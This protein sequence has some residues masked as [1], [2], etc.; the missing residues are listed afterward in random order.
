MIETRNLTKR[1]GD[2]T[3]LSEANFTLERGKIT[4]FIGPNGAGKTTTMKL[5]AQTLTPSSGEMIID[6]REIT[7]TSDHKERLL[8]RRQIGYLAE[9]NPL[10]FDMQC[11][12]FLV[13]NARIR[14]FTGM[15]SRKRVAAVAEQCHLGEVLKSP[16]ALLS[17]GFKQR[18]GV[19]QA[20]IHNPPCLILDEPT[21][22]LDPNQAN[23]F[24][25]TLQGLEGKTILLSTHILHAIPSFCHQVLFIDAGKLKF[26]GPPHD[27]LKDH[28]DMDQAFRAWTEA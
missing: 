5:L 1:Y 7:N 14:G 17:K 2:L 11:G 22:G 21:S 27:F 15:A 19:A 24:I 9:T 12:E 10:Y 18:V 25:Q 3:A 28:G 4:A 26:Q 20:L 6:G 16:I 23:D 13:L 8:I